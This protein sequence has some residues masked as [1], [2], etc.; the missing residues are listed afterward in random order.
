MK[1]K[2]LILS[3][4]LVGSLVSCNTNESS[5]NEQVS[6]TSSIEESSVKQDSSSMKEESSSSI[7]ESSSSV[8]DSSSIEESSSTISD[9]ET[10]NGVIS[11]ISYEKEVT[12][13]FDLVLKKDNV[14]IAYT[15]SD[16][17]FL[18]IENDKAKV[19]RPSETLSDEEITIKAAFTLNE[20]KKEKEY[21]VIVKALKV[22]N[23]NVAEMP[24]E[25]S[26]NVGDSNIQLTGGKITVSLDDN[27]TKDITFA[28]V[29]V[30][31]FDTTTS[32]V[33]K[34]T[35]TYANMDFTLNLGCINKVVNKKLNLNE[36]VVETFEDEFNPVLSFDN[37]QVSNSKIVESDTL[38]G[39]K[40]YYFESTGNYACLYIN[41]GVEFE[42]DCTYT[43]TFD[44]IV[45]SFV[46]T[47]YFQYNYGETKFTQFGSNELDV[48]KHF[49]YTTTLN[50]NNSVIQVFPGGGT[51]KTSLLIDNI[52]IS[53]VLVE[54]NEIVKGALKVN[55]YVLE[56]FGD[57]NNP[58]FSFDFAEANNSNVTTNDAIDAYSLYFESNGEYKGVF[59]KN[60]TLWETNASYTIEF[61]YKVLELSDTIYFQVYNGS[62]VSYEQ[63]G[64]NELGVI[65]HFTWTFNTLDSN[66]VLIK[67]FPGG[68]KGTTKCIIDNLKVT[69][70]ELKKGNV[71]CEGKLQVNNFVSENFDDTENVVLNVD[72]APTKDSSAIKE[73]FEGNCINLVS[74][75]NYLGF[76]I[77]KPGL[78]EANATYTIEFDYYVVSISGA[79]YIKSYSDVEKD[80]QLVAENNKKYHGV[81]VV[82]VGQSAN[83]VLQFFPN[84]ACEVQFDNFKITRNS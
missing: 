13:D 59:L 53:K 22:T 2:Y 7:E 8:E 16:Q 74:S 72:L 52:K 55:E 18:K 58:I 21:V 67:I 24:N 70:N 32:G 48:V 35:C 25:K 28:D 4:L 56:K 45:L 1:R 64:S 34:V 17:T 27:T 31:D 69:R 14:T 63:F 76:Y 9:E 29:I 6:E 81:Y 82:E 84:A 44:Y 78:W 41:G 12:N 60:Q 36:S 19:I 65:K 47:I 66:E 50:G 20:T 39:N 11:S 51:G 79:L 3:L 26:V 73:G 38:T 71:N 61:D 40:A 49:E 57:S 75:G 68:A 5:S 37:S 30:K 80:A 23:I 83:V 62:N 43:V 42:K 46:D 33:K 77:T 15:S 10:I 54:E